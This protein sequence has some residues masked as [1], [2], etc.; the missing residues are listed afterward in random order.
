MKKVTARVSDATAKQL[1]AKDINEIDIIVTEEKKNKKSCNRRRRCGNRPPKAVRQVV[2]W[3]F[4][5]KL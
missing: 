5:I 2:Q 1:K 4:G 3:A